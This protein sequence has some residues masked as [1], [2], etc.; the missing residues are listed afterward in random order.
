[1]RGDLKLA[2]KY[3]FVERRRKV[4]SNVLVIIKVLKGL[5]CVQIENLVEERLTY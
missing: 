5:F 1:M 3:R 2:L 4:H